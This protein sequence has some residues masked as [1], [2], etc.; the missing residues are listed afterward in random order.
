M[1]QEELHEIDFNVK[2]LGNCNVPSPII[3]SKIEGDEVYDYVNEGDRI[4]YDGSTRAIL[5]YQTT[6]NA[7]ISFEKAGPREKLYFDPSKTKVAIVTC[8]GL[9]P[10]L[11]NV[12]RGLVM[13]L[14]RRYGV[15]NV[16]GVKYGLMGFMPQYKFPFVPLTPDI[17]DRIHL[18]GGSYLSSSRGAQ[19]SSVIVDTLQRENINILFCIGGDGTMRAAQKIAD[20]IEKRGVKIAVSCVPKTIDNDISFIDK[21]FGFETAFSQASDICIKAHN[22]AKG[23]YNGIAIVKLMG[24]DSGFIAANTTLATGDVN[25][26]LIPEMKFDLYG[27]KGLINQIKKRVEARQHALIIVAEGA[28]QFFFE[29]SDERDASGNVKYSDIGIYLKDKIQEQFKKEGFPCSIKYIDPS[30]IIRSAAANSNDSKFCNQLAQNAVH[31]AMAGKTAFTVG[32]WNG[33]FTILPIRAA[34]KERKR[35]NLESELWWNVLESTSQPNRMLN[36]DNEP[37]ETHAETPKLD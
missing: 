26:A 20:E 19:D 10:G 28:G 22:E 13:Q 2:N 34:V 33:A 6:G 7:P 29:K 25:F 23:A 31:A 24:R 35:I 16:V 8:G 15:S 17:V 37:A 21:S 1:T 4:L 18:Q 12:I 14:Y 27:E 5:E 9:C 11:N 32:H 36:D 30:Y 3:L